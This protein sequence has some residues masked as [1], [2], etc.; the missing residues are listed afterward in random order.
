MRIIQENVDN[1]MFR[2][3]I[4]EE[5]LD[6]RR[7]VVA[8]IETTG[9]SPRSAKVI[10]GGLVVPDGE[11]R[12]TLQY[13]ADRPEDE[14]EL[15]DRY[16]GMLMQYD[17]IVTYNGNRFDLPFLKK[18]MKIHG[19]PLDGLESFYS[20]DLY[21]I[22]RKYSE[23]PSILPDLKQKTVE[24]Y[25][26]VGQTR[27][28]TIDGGESVRLYYRFLESSGGQKGY[29][30]DRILLHNRDDVV[31][32]SEIMSILRY[33][34]IHKIM[35]CEGFPVLSGSLRAMIRSILVNNRGMTVEGQIFGNPEPY[36]SFSGGTDSEVDEQGR[37]FIQIR[38]EEVESYRVADLK[39]LRLDD[40]E[41]QELPGYESG[42]LILRKPEK[43]VQYH[44]ANRLA[45]K[46]VVRLLEELTHFQQLRSG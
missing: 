31:K 39:N 46:L 14:E 32:L 42:Y 11:G 43:Q 15:L 33:L 1:A 22:V 23:L 2:S 8:D 19:I 20:L 38:T 36:R 18:R 17:V 40:P 12:L 10:L 25:M 28:D 26:G 24:R 3:R 5:Y 7:T 30:L 45:R 29:L 4:L 35:Y 44:E 41:L 37:F 9:L 6:P 13:F 21:R 27:Q 34:D 16:V